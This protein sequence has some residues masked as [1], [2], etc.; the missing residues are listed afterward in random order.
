MIQLEQPTLEEVRYICANVRED[1]RQQAEAFSGKPW[2]ADEVALGIMAK[3]NGVKWV[4]RKDGRPFLIGGYDNVVN[5]VW[6][7]WMLGTMVDWRS[8]W[9]SMTKIARRV[10]D[11]MFEIGARRL[12]TFVLPSRVETCEW[13]VRALKMQLEGELRGYGA[14]GETLAIYARIKE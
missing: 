4:A 7:S 13:Y 10:M 5:E 14:N 12:Q 1:D 8:H 6:Q 9:M 3:D 11:V 2:V